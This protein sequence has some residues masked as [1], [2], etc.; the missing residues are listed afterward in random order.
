MMVPQEIFSA[1]TDISGR[2]NTKCDPRVNDGRI[3]TTCRVVDATDARSGSRAG[4]SAA[5]WQI[6]SAG[7]DVTVR[8]D[9]PPHL[10]DGLRTRVTRD[11]AGSLSACVHRNVD[12][13]T[14]RRNSNAA[15]DGGRLLPTGRT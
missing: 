6:R 11:Y 9:Y 13:V 12:P 4:E 15:G 10:Q 8:P 14:A 2:P 7:H 1:A 3:L 5:V